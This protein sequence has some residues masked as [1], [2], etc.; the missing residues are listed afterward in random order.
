VLFWCA[1]KESS[2]V[3]ITLTAMLRILMAEMHMS[4]QSGGISGRLVL[5]WERLSRRALSMLKEH[6]P[7]LLM[8]S[9]GPGQGVNVKLKTGNMIM[10]NDVAGSE[11]CS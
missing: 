1:G 4:R 11:P 10:M 8:G 5:R 2:T 7:R 9:K 3:F 6:Q